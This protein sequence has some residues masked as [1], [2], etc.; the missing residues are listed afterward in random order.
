[1][2]K[3]W[4]IAALALVSGC[5]NRDEVWDKTPVGTKSIGLNDAI[6]LV[7]DG[8]HRLVLLRPGADQTISTS[9]VDVGKNVLHAEAA[10]DKGRVFVLSGGDVPRR[11][12]N[13]ELP[14]LTVIE[15]I[16]GAYSARRI[17]TS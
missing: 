7:D 3:R 9:T 17:S 1:M 12:A 14:S 6:A 5:G 11:Q 15:R 13:D 4:M 8:A 10:A 16:A 2:K